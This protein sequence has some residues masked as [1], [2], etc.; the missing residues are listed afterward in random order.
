MKFGSF[1]C[2]VYYKVVL[3]EFAG[4]FYLIFKIKLKMLIFGY[5]YNTERK[6]GHIQVYVQIVET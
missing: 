1:K 6:W 5:N 2:G 3:I 4:F